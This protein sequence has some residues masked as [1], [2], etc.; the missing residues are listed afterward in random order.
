MA[1]LNEALRDAIADLQQQDS[2]AIK[3]AF[4]HAMAEISEKI[5][6]PAVHAFPELEPN[7]EIWKS[8]AK[9][10]AVARANAV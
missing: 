1:A 8:V 5:I 2:R 6:N 7:E 3:L 9:A 10:R 4:A